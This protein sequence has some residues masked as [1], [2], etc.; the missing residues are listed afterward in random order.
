MSLKTL[1]PEM[2]CTSRD[3]REWHKELTSTIV[4]DMEIEYF[5]HRATNIVKIHLN[6]LFNSSDWRTTPWA[7]IPVHGTGNSTLGSPVFYGASAGASAY[8][9]LFTLSCGDSTFAV[10]GNLQGSL[11]TGTY[12]SDF[13]TTNELYIPA[14]AWGGTPTAGDY[15]FQ[16]TYRIQQT[17]VSLTSMLAAGYAL[18]SQYS[19]E[20]PNS[21]FFGSRLENKALDFLNRIT[22]PT[23]KNGLAL[24][25]GMRISEDIEPIAIPYEID[26][27]GEDV[28]DYYPNRGSQKGETAL[29][30]D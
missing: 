26:G 16:P 13:T 8:T 30:T 15:Y 21:S 6:V 23:A 25:T 22:D 14:S 20:I 27:Q 10:R 24:D 28:T 5:V 4:S 19:E 2:F 12:T 29:P 11:G 7:G 17:I 9:E 3:V 18:N 1:K